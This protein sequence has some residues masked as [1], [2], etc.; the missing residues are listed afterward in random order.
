MG[1]T[2]T[3]NVEGK[4][5]VYPLMK[6]RVVEIMRMDV[7]E[8]RYIVM[9][10][11]RNIKNVGLVRILKGA[12][13]DLYKL[14]CNNIGYDIAP[15]LNGCARMDNLKLAID[16]LLTD[17]DFEAKKLRLQMQKVNE[18]RKVLQKT[19][20]DQYMTKINLDEKVLMVIDEQSSKGFNGVV[21]QQ[22]VETYKRP[23]IV[24][25]LHNGFISGS[26]RSLNG[27][28]MKTFLN[29]TG[30]IEEAMGHPQAGGITLKEENLD[31]LLT[32][33]NANLPELQEKE[34]VT[35]YDLEI[36]VDE[37]P[38][39]IHAIEKY[40]LLTGNGFPRII[41]KVNGIEINEVNCIGKTHE[42]VKITT[43]NDLELIKFK[44]DDT[45]ASDLGVFDEI[46]VV[47]VLSINEWYHFGLKQKIITNQIM[48]ED[49]KIA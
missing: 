31:D 15:I 40:N 23:A 12:K 11:L 36:H 5:M 7:L 39:Y 42:T 47:G 13:K 3:S 21:A 27:F 34:H 48:I 1:A 44:V 4:D 38:E 25:R 46:E 32:Y 45:Y 29:E 33:I 18:T 30:L 19:I 14:N 6:I 20:V 24:G 17:D 28:D 37:I 49:Y 26:F 10:G 41:V 2:L 22:L 35:Y 9:H 16:I 8:N 43:F